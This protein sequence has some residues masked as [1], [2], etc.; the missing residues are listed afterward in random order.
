MDLAAALI[1][2]I[3]ARRDELNSSRIAHGEAGR[4]E[5]QV[6]PHVQRIVIQVLLPDSP[7]VA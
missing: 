7:R 4:V 3:E 5:I 1:R 2:A 6:N